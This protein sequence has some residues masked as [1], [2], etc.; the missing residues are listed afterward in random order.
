MRII[1]FITAISFLSC[2]QQQQQSTSTTHTSNFPSGKWI[3]L[4]HTFDDNTIYWPTAD[5]FR[6][7]TVSEGMTEGGYYYCAFSYCAAEHGGTH[8]DAPVHFAEGK[9]SVDEIPLDRLMGEAIVI[10]VSKNALPNPDY[11]VNVADFEAWEA[12]NGQ[13]PD[14]AMVLLYTGYSR[15]WP[16]P[17]KYMGTA[18][19][20]VQAVPKLHFPGLAPAAA[21]WL[22]ENR[23]INAIGLDTPSID[24]GQS[25]L[26]ES[27][28]ILFKE[29]IPAFENVANLDKLPAKGSWVIALPMNIKHGSGAPLRII[30]LLNEK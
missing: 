5:G 6:L 25:K 2:T 24:F 21:T 3:D 17:I 23:N 27:H 18:E 7:D 9:H 28:Q 13:I 1:L 26:F 4:T 14:K 12:A 10:D 8:L 20:G 19:K 30:A 11:E 22:V 16:D 29:N 15:Y